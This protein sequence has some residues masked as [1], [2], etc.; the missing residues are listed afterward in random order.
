[1]L[2][3]VRRGQQALESEREFAILERLFYHLK[4]RAERSQ[5]FADAVG[6]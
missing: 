6:V 1:V 5:A 4:I 3:G 2:A